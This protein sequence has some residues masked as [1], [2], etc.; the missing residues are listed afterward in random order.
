MDKLFASGVAPQTVEVEPRGPQPLAGQVL[1]F[2]GGLEAMSRPDAQQKA[3]AAG[4]RISGIISKKVTLV[5]A[6]PG[7]GSKLD[8]ANELDIEVVD[9]H[10]FLRRIGEL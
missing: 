5:V 2:T 10:E 9:E 3:E 4:A 6:G 7:A 8:K 1:V